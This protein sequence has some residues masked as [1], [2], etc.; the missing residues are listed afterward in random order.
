MAKN[1]LATGQFSAW[2]GRNLFAYRNGMTLTRQLTVNEPPLSFL[3]TALSFRLFG[4]STWAA[5]F[6]FALAGMV[7]LLIFALVLR[8]DVGTESWLWIYALGVLAF[9]VTFLL[10]IRQCRYFALSLLFSSLTYY[11][12]RKCLSTKHIVWF[13]FVGF[14]SILLFFSNYLLGG[15]F[16]VS[17][18]ILHLMFNLKDFTIKDW[19][20]VG[21]AVTMFASATLPYTIIHR[22]WDRPAATYGQPESL[23]T[24]KLTLLWWYF[25]EV[26]QTSALPWMILAMVALILFLRKEKKLIRISL[27]WATLGLGNIIVI[28]LVSLQPTNIPMTIADTRYI[29]ASLP[30]FAGLTGVILWL[31]HK[32]KK[33]LGL[34][35]FAIL[36]CSN[37]LTL[38]PFNAEFR[39]LL[40][41]F[42]REV[43]A[44]YPTSISAVSDYL[45]EHARQDDLVGAQPTYFNWPLMYYLGERIKICCALDHRSPLAKDTVRD[46][47]V[48]LFVYEHFPHWF[49]GFGLRP[50]VTRMLRY[51]SRSHLEGQRVVRFQYQLVK[52][53]DVYW[54]QTQ[55]PD[56]LAHSFGPKT[57]FDRNV[58]GVY[59]YR[60]T[61]N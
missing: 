44:P 36:V 53:L 8:E 31:L 7:T 17:L 45:H 51:F 35:M 55:R 40:P 14:S 20:K 1:Y 57:D 30:F 22:I 48:P 2:D 49:V 61:G 23:L 59:I 33:P 10:Y 18:T 26:N 27:E 16:L 50:G 58:E 46:L 43:H 52:K 34:A 25:R 13:I 12:Y 3:L 41:A 47:N 56:L 39:W 5:R 15:A 6:P 32:W 29:I 21:I 4:V 60:R 38:N 9:S 11:A 54:P 19:G 42:I 37:A 24:R 28:A